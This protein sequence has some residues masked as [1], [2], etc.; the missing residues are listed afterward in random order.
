[1]PQISLTSY[2]NSNLFSK[3]YLDKYLDTHPEWG[4]NDHIVV[5]EQIKALYLREAALLETLNE[6]QLEEHFFK[7]IFSLLG[8]E[9]EVTEKTRSREFPDYAFFS[10]FENH[11]MMQ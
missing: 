1:M 6:K 7:P 8:F 10:D 4:K 3:Y 9:F 2:R 5:F 11:A